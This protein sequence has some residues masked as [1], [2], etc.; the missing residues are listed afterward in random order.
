MKCAVIDIGSNSMRLTVYDANQ[1]HFKTLFKEKS[2]AGLAAYVENGCLSAQGLARACASLL[3]FRST[4]ELLGIQ[5]CYVFATASL[6]NIANSEAAA[7]EICAAT[8]F[9]IQIISGKEE[10]RLGYLGVVHDLSAG[11]GI[12][13]DVGGAST[14]LAPFSGGQLKSAE[15][16]PVGSLKLYRDCVKKILPGKA[17]QERILQQLK[18]H[19]GPATEKLP[20]GQRLVCTGG[21]ARAL[22][23]LSQARFSLPSTCRAVSFK[24]LSSLCHTLRQNSRES[25]QLILQAEPEPSTPWSPGP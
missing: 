17:A 25:A 15:S 9:S 1:L 3:D 13:V 8:G 2:M 14:E 22:L 5:D 11:E 18:L 4:L 20:H 19:L 24:Q 10:A 23:R 21:T 7:A 12:F 6:R 16:Y